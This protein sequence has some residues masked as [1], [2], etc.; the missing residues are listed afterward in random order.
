MDKKQQ[1]IPKFI[2]VIAGV[3]VVCIIFLIMVQVPFSQKFDTYQKD[4][5]SA[6]SEISMY[7]DYLRRE[8]EVSQNVAKM[9]AKYEAESQKLFVNGTKTADDIRDMLVDLD[10]D[11][12]QLSVQ[13]G[14]VD[15]EGRVSSSGDPL[16]TTIVEY[17]FSAT[18]E[19]L[20][21]T[22]AYFEKESKGSYYVTNV[23]TRPA[24]RDDDEVLASVPDDKTDES[25]TESGAASSESSS[26]ASSAAV[27]TLNSSVDRNGD[28]IEATMTIKLYYFNPDAREDT[29]VDV[30][31]ESSES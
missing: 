18:E 23:N 27:S 30:A 11:P 12:T 16:Y 15:S 1:S 10:Y 25:G 24:N 31:S 13:K 4:H 20:I 22:L 6:A 7:N 29:E 14:V 21:K 26:K 3:L 17:Q 28:K 19:E 8:K 2:W 5:A 9:K